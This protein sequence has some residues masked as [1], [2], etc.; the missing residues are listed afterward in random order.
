MTLR[1]RH[2]LQQV[3]SAFGHNPY[4]QTSRPS[5]SWG[6]WQCLETTAAS[7][8]QSGHC[9]CRD[10]WGCLQGCQRLLGC[11]WG[12]TG[13]YIHTQKIR[14]LVELLPDTVLLPTSP[15][16]VCW[17]EGQRVQELGRPGFWF[18]GKT[19]IR[20]WAKGCKH[21]WSNLV[22]FY[23]CY[24]TENKYFFF[25]YLILYNIRCIIMNS[26]VECSWHEETLVQC[27]VL[28]RLGRGLVFVQVQFMPLFL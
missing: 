27:D 25:I 12:A 10:V 5:L 2:I 9:A 3:R 13:A 16:Y 4:P 11:H 6:V 26:T 19:V 28:R 14:A 18:H 21:L 22:T 20:I 17:E 7:Y 15:R 23:Q 8:H 24:S 1:E